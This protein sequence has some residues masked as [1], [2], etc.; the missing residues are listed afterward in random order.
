M[1]RVHQIGMVEGLALALV[2]RP[3]EG[4][5]DHAAVAS[6]AAEHDGKVQRVRPPGDR[7]NRS[8]AE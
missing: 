7:D 2:D 5:A 1:R 3:G 8:A 6:L 4:L